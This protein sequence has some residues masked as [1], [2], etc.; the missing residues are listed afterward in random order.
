VELYQGN[1]EDV[2]PHLDINPDLVV[3]DPPRAG[4]V[5]AAI[6][7][8]LKMQPA[9]VV[10]VSCDPSTLAR[11]LKIMH[12]AGYQIES[13]VPLDMFPQTYHIE[14]MVFLKRG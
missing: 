13:M 1:V 9:K 8:I 14:S 5:P 2:L 11:D 12:N 7:S 6:K 3:V 10:Y 4:L